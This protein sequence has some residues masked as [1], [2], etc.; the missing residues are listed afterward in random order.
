MAKEYDAIPDHLAKF[1][2]AQKVFFIASAAGED[3]VNIS[4]K[5]VAPLK[6]LDE[7]T[8]AFADYHGS[9]NKTAEHLAA[10][11]KA[12]IMFTSFDEKPLIVRFF[13]AGRVLARGTEEFDLMAAEHYAAF[14][15][16]CFRQIFLFDVYRVQQSCG[17]GTPR[18]EYIGDRSDEKYFRELLGK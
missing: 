8:V 16:S 14:D 4:P 15:A 6:V 5:G 3:D 10:G 1:A 18:M 9:G 13:C 7:K 11:G 12:T 17:Y 2:M